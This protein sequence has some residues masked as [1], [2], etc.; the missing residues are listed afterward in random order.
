MA[1]TPVAM[2]ASAVRFQA[3]KV[4]SLAYV[5]RTS[6]SSSRAFGSGTSVIETSNSLGAPWRLMNET[7][8]AT[9]ASPYRLRDVGCGQYQAASQ[10]SRSYSKRTGPR[11]AGGR[12]SG[13]S[14]AEGT[15]TAASHR[16]AGR[17]LDCPRRPARLSRET[18][19][20][21]VPGKET[22]GFAVT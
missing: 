22:G 15:G 4:R 10:G 5:K 1:A 17:E 21:R 20:S 16:A 9:G 18:G 11:P 19:P 13:P 6:G 3:R 14:R 12:R 7:T 2:R 8:T